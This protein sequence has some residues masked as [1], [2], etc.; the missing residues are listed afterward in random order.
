MGVVAPGQAVAANP[1]N[2]SWQTDGAVRA[3]AFANGVMYVG[4]QFSAV[5]PP[6]AIVG[7]GKSVRRVNV[8]A[9]NARTGAL[10]KWHPRVGGTVYSIAVSGSRV[11]LGGAFTSVDGIVRDRLAAVTTA[12]ALTR[13]GIRART[14]RSTM[15]R[16]GR[17][18]TS[19]PGAGSGGSAASLEVGLPRS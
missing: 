14:R 18:A 8:A 2:L 6:G 15:W 4:G 17:T 12:G 19:S 16:S 5:R 9:F 3:I 11:Y 13:G 7:S 1:P 10:L